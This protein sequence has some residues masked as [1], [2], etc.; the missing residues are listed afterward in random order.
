MTE[1]KLSD[2]LIGQTLAKDVY[3]EYGML[4]L[5]AG[6]V[7]YQS[8]IR[9]LY[10]HHIAAVTIA[11]KSE[12][13]AVQPP[14]PLLHPHEQNGFFHYEIA[15][16]QIEQLFKQVASGIHPSL[17]QFDQAFAP[18]LEHVRQGWGFL[19]FLYLQ[20]GTQSY[21]ARHS[22]HVGIVSALIG[23]LLEKSP[24]EVHF[25][26]QAGLLHDIG[27]MKIPD[28]LLSKPGQLDADEYEVVKR[29]AIYG[30]Q[31]IRSMEGTSEAMALCALSHHER[32][33]GSGYPEKL[34]GNALSL[35][36]Q[37]ISVADT[38]DALCTDRVYR[39]GI[40]PFEA[41]RILWEQ[42]CCNK[43]NPIIV[44]RFISYIVM[45][46]VGSGALLNNGKYVEVVM[47]H[48]DE[49]MRPLV[50]MGEEFL[51]LRKHRSLHIAKMV[52]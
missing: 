4:L 40:S 39:Q 19:R 9:L 47:I 25:L 17:K 31:I 21:L 5:P 46:Y 10:A 38:F 35:D 22:L 48:A 3:T 16:K 12:T 44:S 11:Q 52:G 27:K 26:G 51:D 36:C 1:V 29:H 8:D 28:E 18:L 6:V 2:S 41:A 37:I 24:E 49:P 32:L 33:D 45:L 20:G 15:V 50:R 7:L 34:T 42:A 30:A 14:R 43:L 13:N 23:Q